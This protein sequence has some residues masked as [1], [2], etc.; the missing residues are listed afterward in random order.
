[1][2]IRSRLLSLGLEEVCDSACFKLLFMQQLLLTG[3]HFDE[4]SY[5]RIQVILLIFV[6]SFIISLFIHQQ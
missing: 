1:V 4:E 5:Q 6:S 3:Y 2:L